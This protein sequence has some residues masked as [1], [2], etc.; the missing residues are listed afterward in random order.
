VSYLV[1]TQQRKSRAALVG[2]IN[3]RKAIP[4]PPTIH[5]GDRLSEATWRGR[6]PTVSFAKV[7]DR[8]ASLMHL[9]IA[10]FLVWRHRPSCLQRV[11]DL[12]HHLDRF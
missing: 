7:L 11:R 9:N 3:G 5:Y 2:K 8:P 4:S 1:A 6:L 10:P 12:M